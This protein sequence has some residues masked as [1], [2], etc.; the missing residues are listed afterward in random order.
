MPHGV[1]G[2]EGMFLFLME[3]VRVD[4]SAID[5][6]NYWKA[7]ELIERE[8][9]SIGMDTHIQRFSDSKGDLPNLIAWKDLGADK[10]IL[11]LSHYDVVPARGPWV[12]EGDAFDPFDPRR[13]GG[14]IYGRGAADD[15]SAI[16]LSLSAC[17]RLRRGE[18]KYNPILAVV[19][20]EEVGGTG[21]VALAEEGLSEVGMR[22]DAVVVIDAAPDFVG[23]GA[24]GV[25]HG[26]LVIKGRGGH[27]GRPFASINPVHLALKLADEL[28]T[29][30]SQLHAS[31]LS[32]IPSPDGSPVP[33]LWGRFSITR[34]EAGTQYNVIP[35]EA[36][37]GFDIRF[38]PEESKEE[39]IARF[40][41]AVSAAACKLGA[42]VE[43]SIEETL[44]PG[45]MTD[46]NDDFVREVLDSYERHFGS[47][48][49]AGSLGGNDGFVFARKGIP[50]VSLGTIE[51]D[52]NAHGDLE[53]V[54]ESV[55]VA[56]RDTL[57][58]LMSLT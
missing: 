55:V 8:A 49:V 38:I 58:D 12:L 53:N 35:S 16:A 50:T 28:L 10:S 41:A 33:K 22:P 37:L 15:K 56:M 19:G 14:R 23:V 54:R 42:D 4:T 48:R 24:S 44:N 34:M 21:V 57:V 40:R 46:P 13:I 17:G 11:L 7:V 51:L 32:V 52:S 20:D 31:R 27:A 2:D 47:R 5:R 36:K 25:I 43:V 3:L 18:A 39:V 6:R 26:E 9:E 45:W 29:G 1:I 30:F